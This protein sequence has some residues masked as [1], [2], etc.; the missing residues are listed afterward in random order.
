VTDS[1]GGGILQ[2]RSTKELAENFR[3]NL[4]NRMTGENSA[5]ALKILHGIRE[6]LLNELSAGRRIPAEIEKLIED[7]PQ[8]RVADEL[9]ISREKFLQLATELFT[10][11]SSVGSTFTLAWSFYDRL[12]TTAFDHTV[13]MLVKEGWQPF[14]MPC[15]VLVSGEL[16]REESVLGNRSRFFFIYRETGENQRDETT[17]LAMRFMAVLSLLFPAISR[18]LH[19]PSAFWYGSDA[20][21]LATA[22]GLLK[23]AAT[24]L[25]EKPGGKSFSLFL[26]TAADMRIVCGD[27]D[28]GQNVIATG[29][30]LLVDYMQNETF[31]YHANTIATMPVAIGIFGRF[32]TAR[33][34][35]NQGKFDLKDMAIDPLTAAVRILSLPLG[36]C[37]TSFPFRMK[38]ILA[39][40]DIGVSLADRL[41]IT[42]QDFMRERL[43][44]ELTGTKDGDGLFLNPDGLD[45]TSKERVREGLEYITT[46][47]RLVHQQLVEVE[48]R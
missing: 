20:E 41:L 19:S 17:S 9:K 8:T 32:K 7:L 11:R 3:K 34:G 4:V 31:R 29:R 39:S 24:D 44:L 25:R 48:Q 15:A 18:N 23:T 43:K 47:Q 21:W 36:G 13:K 46:L 40:G 26:E 42:Y 38:S 5:E 33:S 22:T 12:I 14:V 28:F 45:E 16:G 35:K 27:P 37:G 30:K 2:S 10:R 6:E 1:H